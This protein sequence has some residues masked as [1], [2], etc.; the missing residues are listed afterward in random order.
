[1]WIV[2]GNLWRLLHGSSCTI[3]IVPGCWD[4]WGRKICDKG[5]F[6]ENC[7]ESHSFLKWKRRRYLPHTSNPG[8]IKPRCHLCS[9]GDM[10]VWHIETAIGGLNIKWITHEE[11]L[12]L[13]VKL[14]LKSLSTARVVEPMIWVAMDGVQAI[15]WG[16]ENQLRDV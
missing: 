14:K 3:R 12:E 16:R 15:P 4:D 8:H 9:T 11:A 2:K 6:G 7:T 13:L 1:M 10:V 5:F